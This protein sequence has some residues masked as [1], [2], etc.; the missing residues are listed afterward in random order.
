MSRHEEQVLYQ[1]GSG[2]ERIDAIPHQAE[3]ERHEA[4]EQE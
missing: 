4:M 2:E 3:V 1:E